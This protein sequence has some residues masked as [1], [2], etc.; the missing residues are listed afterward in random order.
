MWLESQGK[1]RKAEKHLK[2]SALMVS[3]SDAKY[4]PRVAGV[5]TNTGS[6]WKKHTPTHYQ[7]QTG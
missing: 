4:Q 6:V 1:K 3:K 7:N 2:Q 5:W